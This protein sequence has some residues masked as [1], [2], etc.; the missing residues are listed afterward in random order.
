[1]ETD[2]GAG[3]AAGSGGMAA[4][5]VGG[6]RSSFVGRHG[7]LEALD[8]LLADARLVTITGVGGVGKT[9]LALTAA[10]RRADRFRD[11][12]RVVPLSPLADGALLAHTVAEAIG[13]T[14]QTP[15]PAQEALAEHLADRRMLLVLDS[16]E[17]L[18]A[19]CAALAVKLL[20][21]APGLRILATSRQ[22][23]GAAEERTLRLACLPLTVAPAAVP[24]GESRS[25]GPRDEPEPRARRES[26]AVT[27]FGDRAAAVRPGFRITRANRADVVELCRRLDGLPLAIELAA[28]HLRSMSPRE[29]LDRLADRFVLL[30]AG[31]RASPPRH[32]RLLTTIGWSHELCTGDER[33]AWARLSVLPGGFD[34]EAARAVCTDESLPAE[35]VRAVLARLADKSILV[36]EGSV[37]VGRAPRYRMLDTLREYGGRWLADLGQHEAVRARMREHYLSLA[38]R[39]EQA[40]LGPDQAGWFARMS[41]EH[42]NLRAALELCL[43]E[44]GDVEVALELAGTLW[45]YWVGA[46]HLAEGR[47][48]LERALGSERAPGA[49]AATVKALWV[50]GYVAVLQGDLPAGISLLIRCR[51]LARVEGDVAAEAYA[52]HRL[53][54]AA[55]IGDH[56]PRAAVLFTEALA[57]YSALGELNSNVLM[58][59][60][61][62][63]LTAAFAGDLDRAVD[64]CEQARDLCDE[65]GERWARSYAVYVLAFA[66]FTRGEGH[67]ATSLAREC[68]ATSHSFHD[69]IA[70]VLSMELLALCAATDGRAEHAAR[71]QGAAGRIWKTV[72]IPRFG[73]AHFSAAH[74]ECRELA[75]SV[76]GER[77]YQA[78]YERG[79]RLGLDEAVA[80]ALGGVDHPAPL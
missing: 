44:S 47:H 11:G 14:D 64:L 12:V 59:W 29:I 55:L 10:G 73:S 26:D 51:A 24:G 61:E 18:V 20:A 31:R 1:M 30:D 5:D 36:E 16:C 67:G 63:A 39:G 41:L 72:G 71:L 62:L 22:A 74:R 3:T 25:G 23:L 38:H 65:Y 46:G 60:V 58:G 40:W 4:G 32:Q 57:R 42:A 76:L 50:L 80:R 15:R 68:L 8:G 48:Y 6:A 43:G 28:V 66:A 53:G 17:H 21:V 34:L 9:R 7:E 2:G 77:G 19:G 49:G 27:L 70:V 54:C 35:A 52:V 79:A 75:R 78:A 13:L 33:L 45:F 69:L 37:A 56:H